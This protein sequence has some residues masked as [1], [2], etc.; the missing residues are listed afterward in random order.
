MPV[1][2]FPGRYRVTP[3][4]FRVLISFLAAFLLGAPC[5]AEALESEGVREE[6]L[7]FGG[8]GG[9]RFSCI[10]VTKVIRLRLTIS[11]DRAL[12]I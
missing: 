1:F 7:L 4:I 8:C 6:P 3:Q 12:S 5:P 2:A 11:E 9:R 10:R